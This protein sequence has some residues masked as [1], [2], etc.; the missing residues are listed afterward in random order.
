ELIYSFQS[1]APQSGFRF[2]TSESTDPLLAG[3]SAS[4]QWRL[5][6]D[7]SGW[8]IVPLNGTSVV[9]YPGGRT[10]A[11]ACGPGSDASCRAATR[12]PAAGY[13][14]TPVAI[15]PE[16]SYVFRVTGS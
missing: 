7:V 4:A 10:T 6:Q 16:Y 9:E 1:N 5:E 15:N 11:L 8:H 3:S 12:A 2:Q 14:T 13:T